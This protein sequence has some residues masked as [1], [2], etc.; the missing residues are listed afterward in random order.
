MAALAA[1][2]IC[3]THAGCS[4]ALPVVSMSTEAASD[5]GAALEAKVESIVSELTQDEKLSLMSG[6][7][8]LTEGMWPTPGVPR[9]GLGGYFMTDGA[10]G[11]AATQFTKDRSQQA[12][13]FPVGSARGATFDP[14]IEERIGEAIGEEARAWGANVYPRTG[15]QRT[16][17][18]GVGPVARNVRRRPTS[19]GNHGRGVRTRGAA[20]RLGEREALRRVRHRDTRFT[21]DVTVD[22]RTLREVFLAPFRAAVAAG[23]GSVMSAYNQVNGSY[24]SENAHLLGILENEW[25]FDGFVESDWIAAVR[26]TAPSVNAG[27]DIEMPLANFS[28]RRSSRRRSPPANSRRASSTTLSDASCESNSNSRIESTPRPLPSTSSGTRNTER[29]RSPPS[30]KPS[31]F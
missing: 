26:S 7:G 15:H 10:R 27:L 29:W 1:L 30:A 3:S 17:P 14:L 2:L 5:A 9:V 11:V 31:C 28:S 19:P 22:E 13:A 25:G 6:T 4:T 16:A 21:V 24:C 12:T 18:S 20:S 8:V 23:V